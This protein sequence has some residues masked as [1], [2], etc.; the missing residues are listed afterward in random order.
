MKKGYRFLHQLVGQEQ[1]HGVNDEEG[2]DKD[3]QMVGIPKGVVASDTT[4]SHR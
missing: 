4:E 3:K 1:E 2:V